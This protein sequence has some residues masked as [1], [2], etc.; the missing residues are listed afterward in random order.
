MR[1][2]QYTRNENITIVYTPTGA[3]TRRASKD[4]LAC[5]ASAADEVRRRKRLEG[6]QTYGVA[7]DRSEQQH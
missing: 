2:V 5:E 7:A 6:N 1:I 3:R 4:N